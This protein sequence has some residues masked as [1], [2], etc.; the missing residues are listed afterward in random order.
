MRPSEVNLRR[1]IAQLIGEIRHER[2]QHIKRAVEYKTVGNTRMAAY[3]TGL[4]DGRTHVLAELRTLQREYTPE[5]EYE[6]PA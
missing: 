2:E 3:H 4:A 6:V 1:R 5:R